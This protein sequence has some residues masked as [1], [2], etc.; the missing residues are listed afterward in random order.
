MTYSTLQKFVS[1]HLAGKEEY[2]AHC[3]HKILIHKSYHQKN[4]K[5]TNDYCKIKVITLMQT[6]LLNNKSF[7]W[8]EGLYFTH[9]WRALV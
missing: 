1:F 3:T 9:M 4:K 5:F 6:L 7:T 8:C 2:S